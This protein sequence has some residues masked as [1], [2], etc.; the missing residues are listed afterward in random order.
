MSA[1]ISEESKTVIESSY[2]DPK[3]IHL[4]MV[5]KLATD[6]INH[7]TEVS[8]LENQYE[9]IFRALDSEGIIK[10]TGVLTFFD[11]HKRLRISEDRAGRKEYLQAIIGSKPTG[12]APQL[13]EID[14]S[15]PQQEKPSILSRLMFWKKK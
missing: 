7:L 5:G 1:G 3:Q 6:P 15:M 12:G 8:S 11:W 2:I 9:S 13:P 14:Y 4:G 10:L